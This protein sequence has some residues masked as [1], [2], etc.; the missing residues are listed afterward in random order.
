MF[1]KTGINIA[2][3]RVSN[4]IIN[5]YYEYLLESPPTVEEEFVAVKEIELF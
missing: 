2:R 5:T 4:H 3:R 1:A